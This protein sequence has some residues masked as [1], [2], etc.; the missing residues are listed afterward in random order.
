MFVLPLQRNF[1]QIMF[2]RCLTY[3]AIVCSR[4]NLLSERQSV[5]SCF[6][7][8]EFRHVFI[9]ETVDTI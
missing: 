7:N 1:V 3:Y 8:L 2:D 9:F 4:E 5:I 6:D